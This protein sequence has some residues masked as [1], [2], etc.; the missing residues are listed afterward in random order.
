MTGGTSSSCGSCAMKIRIASALTKPV[1]TER[2]TYCI[3]RSSRSSHAIDLEHAHQ[4]RGGEQVVD[5]VIAH[6]RDDDHGDRGGRGRDHARASA[7]EGDDDGDRERGVEADARVDPGD[8]GKADR[9][10]NERKRDD[11]PGEDVGARIGQPITT[12]GSETWAF[13]T[14]QGASLRRRWR[15]NRNGRGLIVLRCV[16]CP[17]DKRRGEP[18][19][20]AGS[21]EE[22]LPLPRSRLY[23]KCEE[24]MAATRF[25]RCTALAAK[26]RPAEA[27]RQ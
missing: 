19:G 5:P 15:A 9:F 7:D 8:D 10:G 23:C 11:D 1:T 4:H 14:R 20:G 24:R 3:S 25:R 22:A 12:D 6:Q 26:P 27:R 17:G 2:E 13:D 16:D 21:G 18:P